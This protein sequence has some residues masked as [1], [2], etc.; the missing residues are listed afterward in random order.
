MLEVTTPKDISK[1]CSRPYSS[2][3]P[4]A[5][6]RGG[7][8]K[9]VLPCAQIKV[10]EQTYVRCECALVSAVDREWCRHYLK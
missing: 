5:I 6:L 9:C 10:N 2:L 4:L 7:R 8:N 1:L 3:F